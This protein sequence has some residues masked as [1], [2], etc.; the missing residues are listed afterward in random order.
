VSKSGLTQGDLSAVLMWP[1]AGSLF[2]VMF[3]VLLMPLLKRFVSS[4]CRAP[5]ASP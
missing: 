1:L 5:A 3:L 4:R 2:G